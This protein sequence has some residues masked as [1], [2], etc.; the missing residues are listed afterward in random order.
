MIDNCTSK[1]DLDKKEEQLDKEYEEKRAERDKAAKEEREKQEKEKKEEE[2][3]KARIAAAPWEELTLCHTNLEDMKDRD[4]NP[5]YG[6]TV[7]RVSGRI[8]SGN[9]TIKG[10]VIPGQEPEEG[11]EPEKFPDRDVRLMNNDVAALHHLHGGMKGFDQHIWDAELITD[12][13]KLNDYV[14]VHEDCNKDK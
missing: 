13:K 3:K 2:E 14:E 11:K 12:E 8:A 9:F 6:A 7:G 1:E 10:S 5:Y 4:K